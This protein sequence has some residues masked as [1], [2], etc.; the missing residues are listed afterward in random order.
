[1]NWLKIG[2]IPLFLMFTVGCSTPKKEIEYIPQVI[3]ERP[4][5]SRP[6]PT[7]YPEL[8]LLI[9]GDLLVYREQCRALIRQ[10]NVDKVTMYNQSQ[11]IVNE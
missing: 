3:Y 4:E 5:V 11:G 8:D 10:C 7:P 9:N 2:T 1:M 6:I